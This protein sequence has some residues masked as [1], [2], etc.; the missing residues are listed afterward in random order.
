V[1]NG[2]K[3]RAPLV[4]LAALVAA[5]AAVL[6]F[7]ARRTDPGGAWV[8]LSGGLG[9]SAHAGVDAGWFL[10]DAR[11]ESQRDSLLAPASDAAGVGSVLELAPFTRG[12]S[13]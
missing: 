6:V 2:A 13:R 12:T 5:S 3:G 10:F 9:T 4:A 11:L 7:E 1:W 8:G